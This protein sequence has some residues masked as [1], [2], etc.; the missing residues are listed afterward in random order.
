MASPAERYAAARRRGAAAGHLDRFVADSPFLLDDFQVRGCEAVAAGHGV[1]VAAPTGAGKTVVGEF[2]VHLAL[3]TG[4]KA[5]YTTPIKALS[6]QKYADLSTRHG[7]AQV[8]LLTGD[9][10]VNGEA[11]V[12]VMTTEVLRNMLYSGS[13]TLTGLGFVVMDEVHY[14]ADRFRGPVWEEVIIHL[15][16]SVQVVSLSATVSNAE[17]FGDWLEQV[18]GPTEVIVEE[19]RPVPLWQHMMVGRGVYDL[20]VEQVN[21]GGLND[22]RTGPDPRG[23]GPGEAVRRLN[24][25]LVQAVA[26][27]RDVGRGRSGGPGRYGRR[28]DAGAPGGRHGRSRPLTSGRGGDS[29]SREATQRPARVGRAEMIQRLDRDGLLPAIVF[30]FSR[31]GCEAGV[32]QLLAGGMRL[33][34]PAEGVRIR[35]FVTDRVSA[36]ATEDLQVLGY[37][38]FVEG[39]TRGF[40]AHHAGMLPTFREI[41]EDLF[42]QGRIRTVFATETL[43]LGINMPARTVVL[44]KLIK[45]N[46]ESHVEVTPGEYTQ[47]TGRAGRRGIDVEGHAVVLWHP[48]LEPETVAGLA[49]TRTYPLTSSFRPTYNM[50]VNLVATVGH[51]RAA[52]VLERSFAQFQADRGVVGL[53]TTIRHN[54]DAMAGHDEAMTCHLGDFPQYARLRAELSDAEKRATRHRAADARAEISDSLRRLRP[55]DVVWLDRGHEPGLAVVLTSPD[56]AAAPGSG[57]PGN[58]DARGNRG[59]SRNLPPHGDRVCVTLL[60]H[61]ARVRR[62]DPQDAGQPLEPVGRIVIPRQ[63]N[64]RNSRSRRDLAA[65]MRAQVHSTRARW[66]G[67]APDREEPTTRRSHQRDR[68]REELRAQLRAHPCHRCPDREQHARWAERWWRLH[69]Q[70]EDLR[71]RVESRTHSVAR[72]FDRICNLLIELGYLDPPGEQ[73]TPLGRRLRG[74]YAE[75]DL[76]TAECLRRGVWDHLDPASLAAAVSCLIHE[77]RREDADPNPPQPNADVSAAFQE[78]LGIWQGLAER[79]ARH[80]LPVAAAPD[81]G[82]ALVVHRWAAGQRLGMV[83]RDS[84]LAAGDFVR[85]CKQTVDLLDQVAEAADGRLRATAGAAVSAVLRGVVAADR[86]D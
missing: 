27:A 21:A 62:V 13:D 72:V 65:T 40:A 47:L 81:A 79:E 45:F 15:P 51:Q 31:V 12:V 17:E 35:R 66:P 25:D 46:G 84:D 4:R 80:A 34:P 5:F 43:A 37:D 39:L 30:I 86:L 6:N 1:L 9:S 50:A 38:V 52:G 11:P 48:R 68:R 20:F 8:G 33:I 53:S 26:A 55:G 61:Q 32:D 73:V 28:L 83:L 67:P 70:T 71:R 10:S 54:Q 63:F 76:L 19:H 36:L 74:L 22:R 23:T 14:L 29:G 3:A 56:R 24:P 77:P 60:T 41:V 75:R 64:P 57:R 82:L 16:D 2:A 59:D 85:R 7:A 69:R 18:R 49:A 42:V 58:D 78:M 44:E